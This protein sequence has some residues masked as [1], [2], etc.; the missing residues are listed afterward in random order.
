[1]S[2]NKKIG[3]LVGYK[4]S[5]PNYQRDYAWGE[6]NIE[7]LWDDLLEAKEARMDEMGHFLGAIVVSNNADKLDL[8][9]GQQRLT[10][11]FMLKYALNQRTSNPSFNLNH[12]YDINGNLNLE[13]I[14]SNKDF[15]NKILE[16]AKHN[17]INTKLEDEIKTQ[18]HRNLYDC[19]KSIFNHVKDLTQEQANEL[20]TILNSMIIMLLEEKNA[21]RAI[22]MFQTV[23]DRGVPLLLLDKL[24]ALLILYSNKYCEGCLD[25][26]INERFGK[27]F[28]IITEIKKHDAV[29]TIGG[30]DFRNE[31]ENRI[32]NFHIKSNIEFES[33]SH[34]KN[35]PESTYNELKSVLKD[36][37]KNDNKKLEKWLDI[38]T[39]DLLNFTKCFL[40]LLD[41]TKKNIN[42]FKMLYILNINPFFYPTIIRLKINGLLDDEIIEMISKAEILLYSFGSTNDA[43]AYGLYKYTNNKQSFIENLV[44][45]CK[46]AA[47]G[48]YNTIKEA[49]NELAKDNY[50][51]GKNFKFMFFTYRCKDMR[52]ND[53]LN[54]IE[55]DKKTINIDIEHI[56]PANA[57]ENGSLENYKILNEDDFNTIKNTFGNLLVL[58]SNLNRACQDFSLIKKQ[59]YYKKS[60]ISYNTSFANSDNLI[61]FNK[62]LIEKENKEFAEW[63]KTYF[64]EFL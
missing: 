49:I 63:G 4:F 34:Y 64:R 27:I 55:K 46:N 54:L 21:G 3:E 25:N 9:D 31:A 8:I 36:K 6:K 44:T 19:F 23:N 40:E 59:E 1:M 26:I 38:Y 42:I 5:I 43:K 57:L 61:H 35:S 11:I 2:S 22:R 18:G 29:S 12:F 45:S 48:G 24:K 30:I 62:Q 14:D 52:I 17:H 50:D 58:E 41:D 32:F 13:V 15:F 20:W 47:K 39:N 28:R 37:I 60:K 51:W 7:D 53:Y 10:T 16:Q 33:L 56:I